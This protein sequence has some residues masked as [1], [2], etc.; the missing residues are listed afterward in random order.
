MGARRIIRA[1]ETRGRHDDPEDQPCGRRREWSQV[2]SVEPMNT[3]ATSNLASQPLVHLTILLILIGIGAGI[4]FMV[5]R[6]R[7]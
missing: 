5:R 3:L 6:S 2:P 1:A 4:Y 7:R